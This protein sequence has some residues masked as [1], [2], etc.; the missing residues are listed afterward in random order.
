VV[1]GGRAL[2]HLLA[3]PRRLAKDALALA[4]IALVR[5][6]RD[7]WRTLR[8]THPVRIFTFHR[9]TDVTR[10]QISI[11]PEAFR[12]RVAYV[13]RHH[14]VVDLETA[15]GAIE[16]RQPLRRPL[17]AITFDDGYRSV[18][19]HA[20]PILAERGFS[21]CCFVATGLIGT[22]ERF[23]HDAA[24]PVRAMLEVMD[25]SE[26]AAL[27]SLG[28]NIG[29]HTATHR[30]L[31]ACRPDDYPREI[32]APLAELRGRLGLEQ[33]AIAYP[34]GGRSDID[35][36]ALEA[37]AKAGYRACLS[38]YGGENFPGDALFDVK[39]LHIGGTHHDPLTWRA[40]VHGIDLAVLRRRVPRLRPR[41]AAGVT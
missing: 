30:R 37:I 39:R 36:P 15:L 9:V 8:G 21:A 38:N 17:A 18:F 5:P 10:D 1:P 16:R 31:S 6:V 25:W 7:A 11:S 29:A 3:R 26:L 4:A 33:V 35:A 27:R 41:A 19:D 24:S 40:R 28:W 13:A 34:Y 32:V 14:D 22:G 20:R 23:A 12:Q 2:R